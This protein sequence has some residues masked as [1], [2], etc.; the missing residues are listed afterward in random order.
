MAARLTRFPATRARPSQT[1]TATHPNP[2]SGSTLPQTTRRPKQALT[3]DP[4][5]CHRS[6]STAGEQLA[7][8][9]RV[10]GGGACPAEVRGHGRTHDALPGDRVAAQHNRARDR[11]NQGIGIDAVEDE[12]GALPAR[13]AAADI[14]DRIGQPA[15]AADRESA[16]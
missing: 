8:E 15:G 16:G 4:R 12:V 10:T 14:P 11:T 2:A 1:A 5:L 9:F 13:I 3:A 7:V 6:G